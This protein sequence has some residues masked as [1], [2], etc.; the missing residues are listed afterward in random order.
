MLE[1]WLKEKW[2]KCNYRLDSEISVE[3][4]TQKNYMVWV[5]DGMNNHERRKIK[6]TKAIRQN[7]KFS[8]VVISNDNVAHIIWS[9]KD[10]DNL[11]HFPKITVRKMLL[12]ASKKNSALIEIELLAFLVLTPGAFKIIPIGGWTCRGLKMTVC[13][14]VALF[15]TNFS[16]AKI[17]PNKTREMKLEET[18]CF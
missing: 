7:H 12:K 6:C 14:R 4:S 9:V 17:Y 8:F 2:K 16:C 13:V 18:L 11:Y 3:K 5:K 1:S 10:I 15:S